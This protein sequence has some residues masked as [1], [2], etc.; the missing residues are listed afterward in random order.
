MILRLLDYIIPIVL[1]IAVLFQ[2][3]KKMIQQ[4][5]L[6]TFGLSLN[7]IVWIIYIGIGGFAIL[8]LITLLGGKW[9]FY[10]LARECRKAHAQG[11]RAES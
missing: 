7:T 5:D 8:I 4:P 3:K 2:I 9:I 11:S 10:P 1:M 6:K